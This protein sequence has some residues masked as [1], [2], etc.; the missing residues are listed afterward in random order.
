MSTENSDELAQI[1]AL[2]RAADL[3]AALAANEAKVMNRDEI[4]AAIGDIEPA[5][6]IAD[7]K[8]VEFDRAKAAIERLRAALTASPAPRVDEG[9]LEAFRGLV[10][11]VDALIGESQGVYGLHLNGDP[12]PWSELTQGGRFEEWLAPLETA[13]AA[14]SAAPADAPFQSRVGDWM[15]ACFG[16]E[17]S[18]DR[19]ERNHRFIEEAL[20]LVQSLGASRSECHQLVDYVFDRDVGEPVQEVGGSIVTLAALC[21]AAG[22]DMSAAGETELTRIWTKIDKIR[23]KQAAKPKHSPLPQALP[24][25]E[26]A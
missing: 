17:I 12:A 10:K 19:I 13:R 16:A 7:R 15:Q 8:T 23:A 22:I 11:A 5:L 1:R 2:F 25:K 20:E 18:A 9:M 21:L 14:L 26:G 4:A 24:P 6:K 3:G